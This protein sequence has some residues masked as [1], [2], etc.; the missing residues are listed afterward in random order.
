VVLVV[1]LAALACLIVGLVLAS[2][3]WLIG[4]LVASAVAGGVLWR[5]RHQGA[6]RSASATPKPAQS[7]PTPKPAQSE[8]PVTG[9]ASS[10]AADP[11]GDTSAGDVWVVDRQ[12]DYHTEACSRPSAAERER[13]P[14]AQ[15]IE[16]GFVPC[17]YCAPQ[18]ATDPEP[19]P[20]SGSADVWVIDGRPPYHRETCLIIKDQDAEPIPRVQAGEDGFIPCSMCEPDRAR[21]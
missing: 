20:G 9:T 16:D 8:T 21:L 2:G 6:A 15:A 18:P 4:S 1:L 14:H 10:G 12:P 11:A 5:E 7:P 19:E 3:P 17:R 13:I